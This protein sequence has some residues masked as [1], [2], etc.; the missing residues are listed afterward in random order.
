MDVETDALPGG[1]GTECSHDGNAVE[2]CTGE[3]SVADVQLRHGL[4]E[5]PILR[6][7]NSTFNRG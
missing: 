1:G 6:H 3:V 4:G 5:I 2:D 7:E